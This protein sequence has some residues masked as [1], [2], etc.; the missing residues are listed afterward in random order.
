MKK[1]DNEDI[2]GLLATGRGLSEAAFDKLLDD[3]LGGKTNA[4]KE[5][6]GIEVLNVKLS[7][8]G[9]IKEIDREIKFLEQL[10]G[11]EKYLNMAQLSKNYFGKTK[12]WLYQRLHGWN[13]HGKPARFTDEER[14]QFAD[15]LLSLSDN[16]KNVALK[17]T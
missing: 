11:L 10:D 4:E 2:D 15:A 12:T 14:K 17:L 9:Q 3:W 16:L 13:V 1:D 6:I 7:K 5:K 8:L